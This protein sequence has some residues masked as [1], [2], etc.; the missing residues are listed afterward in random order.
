MSS[1]TQILG[2]YLEGVR[3]TFGER[4]LRNGQYRKSGAVSVTGEWALRTFGKESHASRSERDA[5][6]TQHV[7]R[8]PEGKSDDVAIASFV[9]FDRA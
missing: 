7:Y 3:T 6:L 5:R 9:T 2:A 8:G 1:C 4:R